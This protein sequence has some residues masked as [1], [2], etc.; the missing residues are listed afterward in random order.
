MQITDIHCFRAITMNIA[1]RVFKLVPK[2]RIVTG[3][4]KKRKEDVSGAPGL[5]KSFST[6]SANEEMNTSLDTGISYPVGL[7]SINELPPQEQL[8][9]M[10][11][12]IQ[13]MMAAHSL[14]DE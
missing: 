6:V 8:K 7:G 13:N 4:F 9:W 12:M 1:N 14:N 11:T 3:T 5:V 10:N 2:N